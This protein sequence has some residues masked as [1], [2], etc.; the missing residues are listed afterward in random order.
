MNAPMIDAKEVRKDM[1]LS[2]I[3]ETASVATITCGLLEKNC[4]IQDHAALAYGMRRLIA[5]T[6][7]LAETVNNLTALVKEIE[8]SNES[9]P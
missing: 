5:Y 4:E 2:F 3:A 9:I 6:K 8:G 7:A 1:L